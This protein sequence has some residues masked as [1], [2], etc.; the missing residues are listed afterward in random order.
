M[1]EPLDFCRV[2]KFDEKG[3]GFLKSLYY[4][5]EIF[6]HFS[7][8]KKELFQ[9]KLQAMKHGDFFLYFVSQLQ[10]NGKRKTQK[11]WYSMEEV[12]AEL[13]PEFSARL[14]YDLNEGKTNTFDILHGFSELKRCG[15]LTPELLTAFLS[16]RKIVSMPTTI[17]PFLDKEEIIILKSL[18]NLDSLKDSPSKPFWYD[19]MVNA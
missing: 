17:L 15:Y 7:W 10:E 1:P 18:L 6:F 5:N 19:D 2:K 12:P 9:E 11:I 14:I 4:P 3:Y 13:I 16:A 8:I